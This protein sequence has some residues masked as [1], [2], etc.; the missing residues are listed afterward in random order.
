[1]PLSLQHVGI[2]HSVE[3][4]AS[5]Y[6]VTYA[7]SK[8][9]FWEAGDQTFVARPGDRIFCF[10]RIFSPAG[11]HDS[12]RVRWMYKDP[13]NGWQRRDAVPVAITG[14]REQGFRGFA[15]KANY[16]PGDWQVRIETA[17]EL[18]IGR[19]YLTVEADSQNSAETAPAPRSVSTEIL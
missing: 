1:V 10:F 7:R 2:Y 17:N 3:R 16:Q 5:G 18:E 15:F 19:I 9:R 4:V 13:R 8:W 6:Q 11:F 14:G 12:V